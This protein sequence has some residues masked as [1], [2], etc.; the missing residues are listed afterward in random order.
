MHVRPIIRATCQTPPHLLPPSNSLRPRWAKTSPPTQVRGYNHSQQ[1]RSWVMEIKNGF[2][3]LNKAQDDTKGINGMVRKLSRQPTSLN[4]L[5]R[6]DR[7]R[8]PN[9]QRRY[10]SGSTDGGM[11]RPKHS[12]AVAN[13]PLH[14]IISTSRI[15]YNPHCIL[16]IFITFRVSSK[17]AAFQEKPIPVRR[18]P[19]LLSSLTLSTRNSAFSFLHIHMRPAFFVVG[20]RMPT[21]YRSR[22]PNLHFRVS[23]ISDHPFHHFVHSPPSL[24]I[25][26]LIPPSDSLSP[27][28]SSSLIPASSPFNSI[29]PSSS[30]LQNFFT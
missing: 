6:C 23:C 30:L 28:S 11:F 1:Y 12:K 21:L 4:A 7:Y 9:L 17:P 10:R 13:R 26:S 14:T 8:N 24:H 27:P 2:Q 16:E 19:Y 22:I 20:L 5:Y 3:P 25:S 18:F 15:A 29:I